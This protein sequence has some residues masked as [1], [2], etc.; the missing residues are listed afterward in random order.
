MSAVAF[1]I[2]WNIMLYLMFFLSPRVRKLEERI[3][4]LESERKPDQPKEQSP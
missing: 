3:S 2:A 1:G 4:K